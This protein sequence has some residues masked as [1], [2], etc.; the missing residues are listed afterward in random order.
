MRN[1]LWGKACDYMEKSLQLRKNAEA[2]AELARLYDHLGDRKKSQR[3][4]TESLQ[5]LNRDLPQLPM[6][7]KVARG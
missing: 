5:L 7:S 2:C 6:P 4:F 1:Q 3:F